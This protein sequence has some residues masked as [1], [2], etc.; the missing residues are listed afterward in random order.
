MPCLG[1]V[2]KL[3]KIEITPVTCKTDPIWLTLGLSLYPPLHFIL[4]I[5][6]TLGDFAFFIHIKE[7]FW[8]SS[9]VMLGD[10]KNN[11]KVSA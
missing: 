4:L 3:R 5:C 6:E 2:T 8:C 1:T 10:T 7:F 11:F 9:I